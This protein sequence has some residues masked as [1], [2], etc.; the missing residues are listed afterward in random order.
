MLLRF[1]KYFVF[2]PIKHSN[3]FIIYQEVLHVSALSIGYRK[4]I[5][6]IKKYVPVCAQ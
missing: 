2:S 1:K 6:Y 3:I 4:A 5:Q